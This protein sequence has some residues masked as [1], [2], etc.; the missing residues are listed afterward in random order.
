MKTGCLGGLDNF[1]PVNFIS[2]RGG[3]PPVSFSEAVAQGLAPD[4]GLYLPSVMPRIMADMLKAWEK[5]D[6]AGL[7]EE[8]FALFADLSRD[9][10]HRIVKSAYTRFDVK[11]IAPLKKL[12]DK[13]FVLE[14][15]HGP[16]LAFKDFALQLL[17]GLYEEQI[18]RTGHSINVLGATS[19]DTGAAA[20]HGLLGRKGVRIFIMYPDGRV[21]PLQ[22]RQ[23]TCTR[24]DNVFPLAIPGSFDDAQAALKDV[25]NDA[26]F[27]AEFGLSAVNSINIAR[28]LAQCVYY[29]FAWLKL[30]AKARDNV[31]F[32]VPTG[33]FGNVLAGWMAQRM[34][35]PVKSFCVATN[36]NDILHRFF[37][38]GVYELGPVKPSHAPSMDIQ[39]A[40]NFERFIYYVLNEN[41]ERTKAVMTEFK[42]NG[43]FTFENFD[44]GT[45]RASRADDA[46]IVRIIRDVNA[47][48][49]YV[50]DPHTACGFAKLDPERVSVILAT[51]HPAKFPDVITDAI[52]REVTSPSLE[53]L[54]AKPIVKYKVPA[55]KN[56][57]EDF[58]R[59]HQ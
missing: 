15:F 59:Q 10:L 14:L 43:Q 45:F 54:K 36:Q 44:A 2:T 19:G 49:D 50:V 9:D 8:F 41:G 58:I 39:V 24:A 37:T 18:K 21:S 5:L 17:G 53:T 28:V 48:Y 40:S 56:A 42:K 32:V 23:M 31:E 25:F 47:K 1:N 30:P 13:T 38:T 6:Y 33:N 7:C 16:T 52:G 51:A 57:V 46:E 29:I 4:G 35:L 11:E 20:I 34:G 27:K 55:E 3:C 26:A 12:D 22:E